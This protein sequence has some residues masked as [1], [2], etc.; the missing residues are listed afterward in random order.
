MPGDDD[1]PTLWVIWGSQ[2]VA[3]ALVALDAHGIKHYVRRGK[4]GT[5]GLEDLPGG[6]K[7]VPVLTAGESEGSGRARVASAVCYPRRRA[8]PKRPT[9]P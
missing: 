6:G 3:K 8:D 1:T 7:L 2:Y 9:A 5:G 4:L